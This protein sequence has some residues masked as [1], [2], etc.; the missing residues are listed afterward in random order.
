MLKIDVIISLNGINIAR[1]SKIT[2]LGV[3]IDHK[4]SLK[5]YIAYIKTESMAIIN[6]ALQMLFLH[7]F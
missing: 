5:P 2:V 6:K 1:I 7:L 4:L 3:I